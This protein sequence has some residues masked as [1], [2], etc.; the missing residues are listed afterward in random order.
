MVETGQ[1]EYPWLGDAI[2]KWITVMDFTDMAENLNYNFLRTGN[3]PNEKLVYELADRLGMIIE[4]EVP[5]IKN[6][7]FSAE[8]QEQ[9]LKEMIRRDRNH[10]SIMFWSMGSETNRPVDSKIAVY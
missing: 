7:E 6:Q 4:E 3:Y 5:N 9:Q 10:P 2:P 8:V 1:Q